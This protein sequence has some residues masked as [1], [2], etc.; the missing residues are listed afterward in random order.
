MN[1]LMTLVIM[2]I[3]F[4]VLTVEGYPYKCKV[5]NMVEIQ[6]SHA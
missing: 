4:C 3:V 2:E 6:Y 5:S 1:Y